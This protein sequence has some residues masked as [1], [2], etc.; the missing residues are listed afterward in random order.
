MG[1]KTGHQKGGQR[2]LRV[3]GG[4]AGGGGVAADPDAVWGKR[5]DRYWGGGVRRGAE[6][7]RPLTGEELGGTRQK[8]RAYMRALRH[9]ARARKQNWAGQGEEADDGRRRG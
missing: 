9:L 7:K 2:T 1:G 5:G 4:V 3:V 6:G 8:P